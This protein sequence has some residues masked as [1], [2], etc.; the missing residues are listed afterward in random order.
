M[1]QHL[2]LFVFVI[3]SVSVISCL[4]LDGGIAGDAPVD[5]QNSSSEMSSSYDMSSFDMSSFL[6]QLS[7]SENT[8]SSSAQSSSSSAGQDFCEIQG[9]YNDGECD[10]QCPQPDP[11]CDSLS[12]SS[13]AV[14]TLY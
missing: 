6:N 2:K 9:W 5:S 8:S 11:D 12:S 4:G 14:V 3:L 10:K 7:S 1:N 13:S